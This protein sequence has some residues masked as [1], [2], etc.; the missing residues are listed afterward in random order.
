MSEF[1]GILGLV[2]L[3]VVFGLM[4]RNG[5]QDRCTSC[6][7][8]STDA[9]GTSSCEIVHELSERSHGTP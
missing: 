5:R 3:F 6:S 2:V 7:L 4:H 1:L 9:C 8:K